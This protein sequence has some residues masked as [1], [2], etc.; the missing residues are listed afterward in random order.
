MKIDVSNDKK[1]GRLLKI[2]QMMTRVTSFS[3]EFLRIK[4][5]I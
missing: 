5:H 3:K 1:R 4:D 2:A